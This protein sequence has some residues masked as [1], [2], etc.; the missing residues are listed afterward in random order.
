MSSNVITPTSPWWG[1]APS[2][3]GARPCSWC[4]GARNRLWGPGASPAVWWSW[5]RPWPTPSSENWPEE[6][7]LTVNLLGITAVCE[8]IFPDSDGRIAYHYVLVD[9]LCDYS[10]G[11]LTAG[12]DITAA[13][14]VP[15]ADLP[16]FNL[17]HSPPTSST[18]PGSRSGREA[19]CLSGKRAAPPL[20]I[21]LNFY[22]FP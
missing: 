11:E 15:L 2:S 13:R 20:Q 12:S 3:S 6:T 21:G 14:F 18:G 22:H 10:A 5:G 9:Y 4:A 7:G 19:F 8:R 1:S 16:G 17:P